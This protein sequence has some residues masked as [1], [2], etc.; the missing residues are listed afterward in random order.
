MH[1]LS[2]FIGALHK[3]FFIGHVRRTPLG[4][5]PSATRSFFELDFST[6]RV[7][8]R[9]LYLKKTSEIIIFKAHLLILGTARDLLFLILLYSIE[10]FFMV[11]KSTKV[12]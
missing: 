1:A 6:R 11:F 10:Y 7:A 3:G 8:T 12:K 2:F 5:N 9:F 4:C